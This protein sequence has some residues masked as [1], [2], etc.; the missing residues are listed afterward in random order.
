[1]SDF[2]PPGTVTFVNVDNPDGTTDVV[3]VDVPHD[4]ANN[5]T[6]PPEEKA[7]YDNLLNPAELT[8]PSDQLP[9][10]PLEAVLS[11]R[12]KELQSQ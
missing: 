1:M 2:C 11:A 5:P 4:Y 6:I 9:V 10:T 3:S 12:Q 7:K 8:V